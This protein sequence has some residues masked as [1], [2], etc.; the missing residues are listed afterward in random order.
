MAK[1][2]KINPRGRCGGKRKK[3]KTKTVKYIT[4]NKKLDY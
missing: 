1:Q 3:E 4:E 2:T